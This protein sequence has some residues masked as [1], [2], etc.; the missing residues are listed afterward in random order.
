MNVIWDAGKLFLAIGIEVT[1]M[2]TS[3][4]NG[5]VSAVL[6]LLAETPLHA[7]AGKSSGVIDLPIQREAHTAWPCIYASGV[8]GGLREMAEEQ[9]M[10]E[11][12]LTRIFGGEGTQAEMAGALAVGDASLLLLPV[13]SLTSSF[14]WVTCPEVLRRYKSTCARHG[15]N[16]GATLTVPIAATL[17]DAYS[18]NGGGQNARL[19]LEEFRFTLAPTAVSGDDISALKLCLPIE[20][21]PTL[22]ER[23]LVVH[24]DRFRWFAE[25]ATQVNAHVKLDNKTKTVENGALWYEETLPPETVM[26]APLRGNRSRE[27][28]SS[29]KASDIL[30]KAIG[31][32]SGEDGSPY[33]RFGGNESLG[34]GWCQATVVSATSNAPN[35]QKEG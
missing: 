7:G 16:A 27:A 6:G 18:P 32:F 4:V 10:S 20:F 17:D 34:M 21:H 22:I 19:F 29:L 8:K 1:T 11:D 28:V 30:A 35:L 12:D 13:R 3:G 24:D 26:Y 25:H 31:L 2:N 9:G 5:A 23:L 15:V 14:R 33:V